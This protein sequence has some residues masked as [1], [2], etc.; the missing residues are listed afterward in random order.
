MRDSKM[1]RF[2][3][4]IIYSA[5]QTT[6]LHSLEALIGL[7]DF[8]R[9]NHHK[10]N[11]SMMASPSSTAAYLIYATAWDSDSEDYLR[12]VLSASEGAGEGGVPSALHFEIIWNLS[13]H[14][15]M[16]LLAQAMMHL[17][18]LWDQ[19][20]LPFLKQHMIDNQIPILLL[21][22]LN[23]TLLAQN[24]HGSWVNPPSAEVTSY[25]LLTLTP[26]QSLPLGDAIQHTIRDALVRGRKYLE[27]K[28][29]NDE[30]S[31]YLWIE[32]VTY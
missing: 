8:D 12:H 21:Q 23:R 24:D 10:I 17:V 31:N 30:R 32:K 27:V 5:T 7:I 1:T 18:I 15:S 13:P 26:L 14:Y 9:I 22:A 19:G 11:G 3:P 25:A 6:L 2:H 28:K 16:M 4:S 20:R 29:F